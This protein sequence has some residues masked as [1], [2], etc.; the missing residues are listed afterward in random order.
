MAQSAGQAAQVAAVAV[1]L[2]AAL[3]LAADELDTLRSAALVHDI[4]E[5][6]IA[7]DILG[8]PGPLGRRELV[9]AT[10]AAA[11]TC[12]RPSRPSR[13]AAADSPPPRALGWRRLPDG[14]AGGT[15]PSARRSSPWPTPGWR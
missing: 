13:G 9:R 8:R 14:L 12:S 1:A 3:G 7:P 2:G 10:R 5:V 15:I 11:T 6:A 4:G